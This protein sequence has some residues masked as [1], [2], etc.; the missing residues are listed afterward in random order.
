MLYLPYLAIVGAFALSYLPRMIVAAE[1]SKLAGGYN[2]ND[3]RGQQAQLEGRG[4][5]ALGA[6]QN[7]IEAF[8]PFAAGV[9]A[10]LQRGVAAE[11][12]AALAVGFIVLRTIY[13]FA[14]LGDRATLRS[15]VWGLGMAVVATLMILAII[16]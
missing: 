16:G 9:L 5:R 11:L 6:H 10:A 8:A 1:M 4:K 7:A 14:Y 12:V 2:N 13:M 3:P 15:S